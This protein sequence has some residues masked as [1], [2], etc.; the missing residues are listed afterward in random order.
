MLI[1]IFTGRLKYPTIMNLLFSVLRY[2]VFGLTVLACFPILSLTDQPPKKGNFIFQDAQQPGPF[3]SFG[4]FTIDK[5]QSQ[6]FL[7]PNYLKGVQQSYVTISP[8]FIYGITDNLSVLMSTPIAASYHEHSNQSSGLSDTSI[9]VE[10]A[11]INTANRHYFGQASIMGAVS[12]PTGSLSKTPSTGYGS[13]S[14]FIG[15]SYN[16]MYVDWYWFVAQGALWITP[17]HDTRLGAKY[18][19]DFGIGKNLVA[20]PG[21]YFWFA[22]LE[23]NGDY[24]GK[25]KMAGFNDPDSGGNIIFISPSLLYS[26]EKLT[27]QFG[28]ALPVYQ[29][30]NGIQPQINYNTSLA[31]GW[32]FN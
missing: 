3:Y 18:L 17:N 27:L 22:L 8:S 28:V 26:T 6:L 12:I 25:N 15:G 5:D 13:P 1:D 16:R 7:N 32:T 19:Y 2:I 24:A 30:L 29:Q 20:K 21:R 11:L 31:I 10:Y 23:L 14:V 4:Q 9:Q